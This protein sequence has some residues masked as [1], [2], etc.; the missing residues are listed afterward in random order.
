MFALARKRS[1]GEAKLEKLRAIIGD[2]TVVD[3]R[4]QPVIDRYAEINAYSEQ[5][6]HAMGNNDTWIAATAAAAPAW[7][8]TTDRDFDHLHP[9][10][11]QREWIDPGT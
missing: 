7:L 11:I 1:W 3:I 6:G 8:L 10:F 2:L 5:A 9:N 4:P